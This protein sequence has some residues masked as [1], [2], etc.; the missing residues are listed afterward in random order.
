MRTL[1]LFPLMMALSLIPPE[2][3]RGCTAFFLKS[4]KQM[5]LAKNLDWPVEYRI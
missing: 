3:A 1:L 2:Q 5:V 4:R